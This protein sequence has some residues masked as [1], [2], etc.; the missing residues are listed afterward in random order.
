MVELSGKADAINHTDTKLFHNQITN[1]FNHY[2]RQPINL[3][4]CIVSNINDDIIYNKEKFDDIVVAVKQC[5]N[6]KNNELDYTSLLSFFREADK[7]IDQV[8][9]SL[10][11]MVYILESHIDMILFET[12][13]SNPNISQFDIKFKLED[14]LS[15]WHGDYLKKKI[16]YSV[17]YDQKLISNS[18]EEMSNCSYVFW[19]TDTIKFATIFMS[20]V[21]NC[22][23]HAFVA[24]EKKD[25]DNT[26]SNNKIDIIVKMVTNDVISISVCD[27]GKGIDQETLTQIR[28]YINDTHY[29]AMPYQSNMLQLT[30]GLKKCAFFQKYLGWPKHQNLVINS[31]VGIGTSVTFFLKL[32]EDESIWNQACL[33]NMTDKWK[34]DKVLMNESIDLCRKSIPSSFT[35]FKGYSDSS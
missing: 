19:K 14:I 7:S 33:D 23:K 24:Y 11:H 27:N 18:V 6:C 9:I 28:E 22:I 16:K 29:K 3:V 10:T 1:S 30:L 17:V 32:I 25:I 35:D 8:L 13:Q 21:D 26:N 15:I 20:L 5:N 31:D 4:Y 34:L 12:E 2:I